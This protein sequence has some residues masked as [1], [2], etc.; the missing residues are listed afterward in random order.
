MVDAIVPEVVVLG[1][2]GEVCCALGNDQLLQL[3]GG[4][5]Q[6]VLLF[7]TVPVG[8]AGLELAELQVCPFKARTQL[9][10]ALE[11]IGGLCGA[12]QREIGGGALEVGQI[13]AGIAG[14]GGI[15]VGEGISSGA[16]GEVSLC[17]VEEGVDGSVSRDIGDG[18]G[19]YSSQKAGGDG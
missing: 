10:A 1:V 17:L 11:V 15:V 18:E 6:L 9:E 4:F 13:V 14:H 3:D 5:G 2:D 7:G 16:L 12:A 19:G 8:G